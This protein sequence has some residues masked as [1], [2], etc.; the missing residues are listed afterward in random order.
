MRFSRLIG[1]TFALL[2]FSC[3]A[4]CG[5]I[6]WDPVKQGKYVCALTGDRS[7]NIWVGTEDSGTWRLVADDKVQVSGFRDGAPVAIDLVTQDGN[8]N[9][10]VNYT[11]KDGL[12]EDTTYALA[13]DQQGRIWAGHCNHGV[14]VF[15][16]GRWKNY[17]VTDGPLGER[18]WGIT[19]SPVDGNVWIAHNAGLTR[20]RIKEDDWQHITR[21][22]GLPCVA[23][24]KVSFAPNG[25][26][27][28][29]TECDGLAIARAAD[30]Y[31][32]W[33]NVRGVDI[34]PSL[35]CG[36][37]L[38]SNLMND[39]LVAK[40]G[41]VWAAT[42][43]GVAYSVDA[44]ATWR[45]R[46]G[47]DWLPKAKWLAWQQELQPAIIPAQGATAAKLQAGSEKVITGGSNAPVEPT[48]LSEMSEDYVS[49]LAEGNGGLIL[50]GHRRTGLDSLRRTDTPSA[51]VS[52][53]SFPG[54]T[55]LAPNVQHASEAFECQAIKLEGAGDF[56]RAV[57]PMN[58]GRILVGT[59]GDGLLQAGTRAPNIDA[60]GSRILTANRIGA[61]GCGSL[62]P[63]LYR[64]PAL[65]E[66]QT[67]AAQPVAPI[68]QNAGLCRGSRTRRTGKERRCRACGRRCFRALPACLLCDACECRGVKFDGKV[69]P[70]LWPGH[71]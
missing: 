34:P 1:I 24:I 11:T 40:N 29:A 5:E 30:N 32:K 3:A 12:G 59:Y 67:T 43:G 14:S 39:L 23:V 46:R 35:P 13:C 48:L 58:D 16:G 37:G 41:T 63:V 44:G 19:V 4:V 8:H 15:S 65:A 2:S 27:Y 26:L 71:V 18:I 56:I 20:Y 50:A 17:G 57:L 60:V 55:G 52:P 42:T 38:P 25:D 9:H 61:T 64:A 66:P 6:K 10:W 33:Q 31:A 53:A 47:A 36:E 51:G 70:R 28:A 54:D 68:G 22:Q 49:C 45:F 69:N 62:Q 7:G 21:A